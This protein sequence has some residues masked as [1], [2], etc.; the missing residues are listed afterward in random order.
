MFKKGMKVTGTYMRETQVTGTVYAADNQTVW[1]ES[2][3]YMYTCPI[4]SVSV[5][6]KKAKKHVVINEGI[7]GSR[8]V[9]NLE[10]GRYIKR[11]ELLIEV[12][13]TEQVTDKTVRI[14]GRYIDSGEA[15]SENKRS[16]TIIQ[17]YSRTNIRQAI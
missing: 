4:A 1:I 11:N 10:N 5:V 8:Y 15:Y 12:I 3:E 14:Y 16:S 17:T 9:T 7:S 6:E 2:G 13:G